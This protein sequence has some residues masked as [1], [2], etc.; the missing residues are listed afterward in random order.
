MTAAPIAE[1]ARRLVGVPF[2][3]HGR[4][5]QTGVDCVGLV[6][7]AL[8][9]IGAVTVS[10]K[11]YALRQTSIAHLLPLATENG[12]EPASGAPQPGDLILFA[13]P[14]AQHH[15]AI[16]LCGERIVH[17]HAGLKRV[18]EGMPGNGWRIE[19]IW[20]HSLRIKE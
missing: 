14:A 13:L 4:D 16:C 19:Q 3:L 11:N 17:A 20:R 7:A 5:P 10:P 12:F 15:V 9:S 2:R 6:L 18:V 1:A 8:D